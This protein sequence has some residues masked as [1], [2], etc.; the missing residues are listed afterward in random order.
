MVAP[1]RLRDRLKKSE[2]KAQPRIK[3][4]QETT[5]VQPPSFLHGQVSCPPPPL[6]FGFRRRASAIWG[7]RNKREGFE[8]ERES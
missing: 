4:I 2:H 8:R 1:T 3:A 7:E 6:T 5:G